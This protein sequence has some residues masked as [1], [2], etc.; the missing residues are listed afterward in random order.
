M[1][2]KIGLKYLMIANMWRIKIAQ[3][4][5]NKQWSFMRKV[6]G[7]IDQCFLKCGQQPNGGLCKV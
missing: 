2:D 7:I 1:R 4:L 6:A 3:F 5:H